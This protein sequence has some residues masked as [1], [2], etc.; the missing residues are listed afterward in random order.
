M[1]ASF[2]LSLREGIEA[3]LVI[4]ILLGALGKIGR[5]ELKRPVWAGAIGAMA[6]SLA[7]GVILFR[8]GAL[9]EGDAEKIF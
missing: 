8:L 6:V 1:F 4:G 9:F 3:A 5:P 7:A 2:L